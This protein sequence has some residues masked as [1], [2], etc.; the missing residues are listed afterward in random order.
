MNDGKSTA[1]WTPDKMAKRRESVNKSTWRVFALVLL[2]PFASALNA[3]SKQVLPLNPQLSTGCF[4]LSV[5]WR[6]R[7]PGLKSLEHPTIYSVNRGIF[8]KGLIGVFVENA[9]YN[10][11]ITYVITRL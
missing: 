5:S 10:T 4:L 7:S 3:Q 8:G 2:G 9:R 1:T 11:L 6:T